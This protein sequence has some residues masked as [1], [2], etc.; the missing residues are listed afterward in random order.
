MSRQPRPSFRKLSRSRVFL[1][2]V[3]NM[4][5]V[6]STTPPQLASVGAWVTTMPSS[7]ASS[8]SISSTPTVYLATMRRPSD[9]IITSLLMR[10]PLMEVPT[11][12]S[13]WAAIST[14]FSC[15]SPVASAQEALPTVRSQPSSR[16]FS[17]LVSSDAANTNTFGLGM[18]DLPQLTQECKLAERAP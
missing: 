8:M 4:V 9:A 12:A 11:R 10:A 1:S 13:A 7:V 18:L 15:E 2:K 16:S 14:S 3:S 17:R 5:T 6:L